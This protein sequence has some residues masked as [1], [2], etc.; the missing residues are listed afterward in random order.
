MLVVMKW[1]TI[2]DKLKDA[3][4]SVVHRATGVP[5]RTIHRLASGCTKS[6]SMKTYMAL[7]H[8]ARKTAKAPA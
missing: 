1:D 5:L 2:L 8:W 6:P 4:P 7:E 3:R